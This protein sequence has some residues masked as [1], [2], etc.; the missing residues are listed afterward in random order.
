NEI[1][2]CR[3]RYFTDGVIF[4]SRTFVEDRFLKYRKNFGA[5]RETG[6]RPMK[7]ADFGSLCTARELRLNV[8]GGGVPA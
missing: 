8:Y 6:A 1:L 7:G 2:R 4:G 3:V 5:K